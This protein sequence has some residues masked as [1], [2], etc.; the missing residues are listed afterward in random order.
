MLG[1]PS[2]AR[3]RI[4]WPLC[5]RPSCWGT[6]PSHRG[7]LVTPSGTGAASQPR[8]KHPPGTPC[9]LPALNLPAEQPLC[10]RDGGEIREHLP[11]RSDEKRRRL[12]SAGSPSV[13]TIFAW[14]DL[15]SGPRG[16]PFPRL[17]ASKP[18]GLVSA[19]RIREKRSAT[20]LAWLFS[21]PAHLLRGHVLVPRHP[22]LF[23]SLP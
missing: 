8:T 1:C 13:L 4:F 7:E 20:M 17:S 21:A 16:F 14:S 19:T 2:S 18:C 15:T 11:K 10:I 23:S 12:L 5:S 3:A 9:A 6:F 22:M